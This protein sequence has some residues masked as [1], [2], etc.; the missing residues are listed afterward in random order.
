MC[1]AEGNARLLVGEI[2]R[3]KYIYY[4]CNA[5][6]VAG[7][8]P[9]FVREEVLSDLFTPHLKRLSLDGPV[10]EWLKTALRG[11][12]EDKQKFHDA[13]VAR[14]TKQYANLQRKLDLTYDDRLEGRLTLEQYEA[15]AN[16]S[17]EEMAHVRGELARYENADRAYTE[18][19]IALL[20]LSGMALELYEE[21]DAPACLST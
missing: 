5:C 8:K 16:A 17:R 13:A 20:E 4:H 14:L 7:R 19:G 15:R 10:V 2:Q 6:Q 21:E 3:K 18:E 11:S 9:K 1:A 12:H